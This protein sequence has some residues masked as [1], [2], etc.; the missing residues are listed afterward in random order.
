M[1]DLPGCRYSDLLKGAFAGPEPLAQLPRGE[2]S[3]RQR[4]SPPPKPSIQAMTEQA[5]QEIA[6]DLDQQLRASLLDAAQYLEDARPHWA[7]FYRQVFA[8]GG[9][10]YQVYPHAD[11]RY[12]FTQ[13]DEYR[14]LKAMLN[15][16]RSIV[17]GGAQRVIT[18]RLPPELHEAL[19][20]EAKDK[21]AS[22]NTIAVAKLL[23][24]LES[25]ALLETIERDSA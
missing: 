4:F 23:Q 11:D 5:R 10:I 12:E 1:P 15:S 24:E 14:Q 25:D 18:V 3:R 6:A 16:L 2:A 9:L 8:P 7:M 13:T 22:L 17:V 19:K 21:G 20:A